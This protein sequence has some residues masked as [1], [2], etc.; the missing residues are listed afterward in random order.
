MKKI[1]LLSLIIALII[2]SCTQQEV[3]SRI[4]G[5]WQRVS[6]TWVSGDTITN[7]NLPSPE[8]G[9]QIKMW[10]KD[11]WTFVGIIK[12]DTTDVDLYGGGTYTLN[13]NKYEENII[14]HND[15]PSINTKFKALLEI[16]NDT[17]IQINNILEDWKRPSRYGIEKYVR[18]E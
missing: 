3:K 15:K 10:T 7:Y 14:Y 16:K 1:I 8:L 12:T 9:S 6:F 5:V 11:Y 2:G 4:E 13:G 18:A 17:L